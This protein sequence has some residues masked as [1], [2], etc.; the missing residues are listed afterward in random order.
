MNRNALVKAFLVSLWIHDGLGEQY[1]C[2][3]IEAFE[4]HQTAALDSEL[5]LFTLSISYSNMLYN[6]CMILLYVCNWV[7][8]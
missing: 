2:T 6:V 5:T 8:I 4:Q 3:I 7:Y 1:A